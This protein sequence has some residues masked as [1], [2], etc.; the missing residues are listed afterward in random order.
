[1]SIPLP[2]DPRFENL[3]GR[4]FGRL[5]VLNYAGCRYPGRSTGGHRWLCECSCGT[6][7][8]VDGGPLKSSRQ[9]SC[10]C[11]LQERRTKHG[12]CG[13]PEY[14]VWQG[15]TQRCTN[16]NDSKYADYGGRGITICERWRDFANFFADMGERPSPRHTLERKNNNSGYEPG[17]CCWATRKQQLRNRRNNH[18]VTFRGETLCL[19]EWAERTGININTLR[20]RLRKWPAE[21][22]LATPPAT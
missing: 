13:S 17:N 21:R 12:R 14:V 19:V 18:R 1:M 22:A 16:P 5:T 20:K 10:G 9:V 7:K 11:Y 3:T 6:K 8:T 15:M 2:S 4:V